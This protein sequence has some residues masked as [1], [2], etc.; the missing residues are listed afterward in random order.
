MKIQILTKNE[1]AIEFKENSD[2]FLYYKTGHFTN[3]DSFKN[4]I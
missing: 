4:F 1:D 3:E 2:T